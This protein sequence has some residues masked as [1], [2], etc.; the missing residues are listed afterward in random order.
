MF[1]REMVGEPMPWWVGLMGFVGFGLKQL[2]QFFLESFDGA[3]HFRV[4][5][6]IGDR[7]PQPAATRRV[8]SSSTQPS[9]IAATRS[10]ISGA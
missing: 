3:S 10:G 9:S 7:L 6:L 5:R 4:A 1:A 2:L 8:P